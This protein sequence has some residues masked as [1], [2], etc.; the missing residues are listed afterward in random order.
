[1]QSITHGEQSLEYIEVSLDDITV[2]NRLAHEVLGRTLDELSP[3]TRHLLMLI[4]E[5]VS[6][7]TVELAMNQTEFRFTRKD[8]RGFTGWSDFQVKTHMRKLE[9]LEY[10]LVHRGG[11]GHSFV[12]ELLYRG[13]G[14]DGESFVMG[15]VDT[16][17]LTKNYDEH[18]EGAP[19]HKERVS[20]PQR[21]PKAPLGS[22][23]RSPDTTEENRRSMDDDPDTLKGTT[24]GCAGTHPVV[25]TRR[26]TG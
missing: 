7:K 19:T 16:A 13:E 17:R 6:D 20:R 22:P 9:D 4:T 10:V 25:S 5:Y 3:Q 26:K 24:T 18:K 1:M 14:Q 21:G 15:L 2:A 23:D 11:R 12:Y 8:V